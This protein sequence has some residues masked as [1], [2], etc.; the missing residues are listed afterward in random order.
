MMS[1]RGNIHVWL[2]C[3][4]IRSPR[5]SMVFN[6]Q[7]PD[8]HSFGTA[9][10]DVHSF[11]TDPPDVHSFGTDPPDVHSFGTDPSLVYLW[12]DRTLSQSF[13][14]FSQHVD[15]QRIFTL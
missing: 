12:A 2:E 11:G 14:K 1:L 4:K 6:W 3:T 9:P 7:P 15:P 8:V 5:I 10:P 13:T